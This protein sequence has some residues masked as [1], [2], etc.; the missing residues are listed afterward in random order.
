MFS[1]THMVVTVKRASNLIVKSKGDGV[2]DSYAVIEF[3][4]EKYATSCEKSNSP[5]WNT[6][7]SFPLPKGGVFRSSTTVT[8]SVFNKKHGRLVVES[9]DLIG[10][11]SASLVDLNPSD[12]R[13]QCRIYE[14]IG[15]KKDSKKNRGTIEVSF[16]FVAK[17]IDPLNQLPQEKKTPKLRGKFFHKKSNQSRESIEGSNQ[18]GVRMRRRSEDEDSGLGLTNEKRKSFVGKSY[19]N[20]SAMF[21]NNSLTKNP[22]SARGSKRH[23]SVG[24]LHSSKAMSME[25]LNSNNVHRS[26]SSSSHKKPQNSPLL[27][28]ENARRKYTSNISLNSIEEVVTKKKEQMKSN[29][30]LKPNITT[31]P[32]PTSRK[33]SNI[34]TN[35]PPTNRKMSAEVRKL[36]KKRASTSSGGDSNK[37]MALTKE[38]LVEIINNNQDC[39]KNKNKQIKELEDYID[40]LRLKV[41]LLEPRLLDKSC[42]IKYK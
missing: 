40:E 39:I 4:K 20:I 7:C 18:S 42:T 28:D 30:V 31:N 27:V 17:D 1:P 24:G 34:T 3:N 19:E 16:K 21:R 13:E 29:M 23:L 25:V 22:S 26:N 14:L 15:K 12:D 33:L 36:M 6:E 38:Q 9:D 41:M 11:Y 35:P 37:L 2:N 10:L 5:K 32:P 8:L